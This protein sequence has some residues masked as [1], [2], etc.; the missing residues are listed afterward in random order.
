MRWR[1]DIP[2]QAVAL[3]EVDLSRIPSFKGK[4]VLGA[5]GDDFESETLRGSGAQGHFLERSRLEVLP[6]IP[7]GHAG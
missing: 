5:N 2:V 1:I 3:I 6:N 7:P 4:D